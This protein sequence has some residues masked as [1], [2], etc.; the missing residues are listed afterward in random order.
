M[1]VDKS[2]ENADALAFRVD[3]IQNV[4]LDPRA[5]ILQYA[6]MFTSFT[7][8]MRA[9]RLAMPPPAFYVKMSDWPGPRFGRRA[10]AIS[11]LLC[12]RA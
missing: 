2:F 8:E 6:H 12:G 4:G 1:K 11:A 9:K 3:G 5:D 10:P 7:Q